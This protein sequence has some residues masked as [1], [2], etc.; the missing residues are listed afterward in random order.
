MTEYTQPYFKFWSTS[1]ES[2]EKISSAAFK[3]VNLYPSS[4]QTQLTFGSVYVYKLYFLLQKIFIFWDGLH[5][6]KLS[7]FYFLLFSHEIITLPTS[8]ISVFW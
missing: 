8:F 3:S 2:G 1:R 6:L 7:V 4:Y 5:S